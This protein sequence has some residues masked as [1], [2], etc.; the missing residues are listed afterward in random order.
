YD[1]LSTV[2]A[3][4]AASEGVRD[5]VQ[6]FQPPRHPDADRQTQRSNHESHRLTSGMIQ[7]TNHALD[8]RLG[9]GAAGAWPARRDAATIER[10]G[11]EGIHGG[12]HPGASPCLWGDGSVRSLRYGLPAR[13]LCSLWGWND[14]IQITGID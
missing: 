14:G 1:R 9:A 4:W 5:G 8:F 7:D 3:G 12:P 13:T 6:I 11:Y 2:D 10:T